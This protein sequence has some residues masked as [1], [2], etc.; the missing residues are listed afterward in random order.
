MMQIFVGG[1]V[2]LVWLVL[3]F[4]SPCMGTQGLLHAEQALYHWATAKV[5]SFFILVSIVKTEG[6]EKTVRHNEVSEFLLPSMD[7]ERI[8]A[9]TVKIQK[10]IYLMILAIFYC[11]DEIKPINDLFM[12]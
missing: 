10:Q 5:P 11:I 2:A 1:W 3:G 7:K 4:D 6:K 9:K 8:N 12:I